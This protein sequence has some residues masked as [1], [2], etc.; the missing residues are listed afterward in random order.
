[1]L[2]VGIY[3]LLLPQINTNT[4]NGKKTTDDGIILSLFLVAVKKKQ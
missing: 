1:M 4:D 2:Q 3:P